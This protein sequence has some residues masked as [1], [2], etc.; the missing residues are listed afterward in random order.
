MKLQIRFGSTAPPIAEQLKVSRVKAHYKDVKTWQGDADAITQLF[1][2]G[3][4]SESETAK[5]R[6]KL[7]KDIIGG[8]IAEGER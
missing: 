1:V 3:I 6:R 2:R 7:A 4:L 5:C 8:V